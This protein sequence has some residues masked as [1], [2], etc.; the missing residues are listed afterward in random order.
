[1]FLFESTTRDLARA[2]GGLIT[3]VF[4]RLQPMF[5]RGGVV[6][7]VIVLAGGTAL[8]QVLTVAFSPVITRL[9]TPHDFGLLSVYT[10]ILSVLAIVGCWSY[11]QAIP[12]PRDDESAVRLIVLS[13]SIV[14][15]MS[16]VTAVAL[17]FAGD[18]VLS[19]INARDLL[20]QMFLLPI[21]LFVL[22]FYQTLSYWAVRKRS[23]GVLARTKVNQSIGQVTVQVGAGLLDRGLVGLI[24]GDIVGRASGGFALARIVLKE[25][26]SSF[27]TLSVEGLRHVAYRYRRFPLFSTGSGLLTGMGA[28]APIVLSTYYGTQVA[29]FVALCQL[30]IGTPLTLL[31]VSVGRVYLG[32]SARISKADAEAQIRLFRNIVVHMASVV[33][34]IVVVAAVLAPWVVPFVFGKQWEVSVPFFQVLAPSFIFLSVGSPTFLVLDVFERQDRHLLRE[35]L[36]GPLVLGPLLVASAAGG[37]PLLGVTL[38]GCGVSVFYLIGMYLSWRVICASK[39]TGKDT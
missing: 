25:A 16:C 35:I 27:R 36:R 32:E 19:K 6:R 21:G 1:M 11:E 38:Y 10:S 29:G 12:L 17:W 3:R 24:L 28:F 14:A 13:M 2:T 22:S 7:N 34:P 26:E 20:P 37:S 23:Y 9:Y 30:F 15:M 33:V 18:F 4:P 5:R 31:S 39:P 8:A